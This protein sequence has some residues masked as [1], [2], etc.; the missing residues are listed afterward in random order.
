MNIDEIMKEELA[1]AVEKKMK[2]AGINTGSRMSASANVGRDPVLRSRMTSRPPNPFVKKERRMTEWRK[3]MDVLDEM[4]D[5]I[6]SY[7]GD[8]GPEV[9]NSRGY[10]LTEFVAVP[11]IH[12]DAEV[13]EPC[14]EDVIHN[15]R[16]TMFLQWANRNREKYVRLR[17][18]ICNAVEMGG[19]V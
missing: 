6:V 4:L 19:G 9:R 1:K 10:V 3:R 12:C 15:E 14:T 17:N 5:G 11:C 7:E 2:K 16:R 18:R 13:G 8:F